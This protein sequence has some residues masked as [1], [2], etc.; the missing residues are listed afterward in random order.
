MQF[1]QGAHFSLSNLSKVQGQ[2]IQSLSLG[3]VVRSKEVEVKSSKSV[4][5]STVASLTEAA[6]RGFCYPHAKPRV[7]K[8]YATP[9]RDF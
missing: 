9:I 1:I 5:S 2:L 7:A 3:S 6:L 4:T 8:V